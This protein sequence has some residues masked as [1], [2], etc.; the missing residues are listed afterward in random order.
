MINK[1]EDNE[2]LKSKKA[3]DGIV[4][5]MLEGWLKEKKWKL[6]KITMKRQRL[7]TPSLFF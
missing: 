1:P 2:C 3:A 7:Y 5:T 4:L 6:K